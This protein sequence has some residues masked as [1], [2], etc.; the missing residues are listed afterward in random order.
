[1]TEFIDTIIVGG[2]QGGLSVSYHLCQQGREH[3]IFEKAHRAAQVWRNRWD[4]FT[5]ITPNWMVRMP[6]APYQ[7]DNPDGFM[8]KDEIVTYF[9]SYINRFKLPI[10]YGVRVTSIKPYNNGYRVFTNNGNY[11][12]KNVVVAVGLYQKAKMP[13]CYKKLS[14][15]IQQIHSSEYK[16]PEMLPPGAVLVVGSGQSGSQIAEELYQSG[17]KVFL[18]V[19]AAGRVPRRYRGL[20]VAL[21]MEKMGYY[22]R[23][24]SELSSP[25]DK[26]A[27]SAHGTGKNGG[28]TIN[29]HQFA[30]EG[31]ILLGQVKDIDNETL[32]IKMNLKENL[33]KA[34]QFEQDFI[35]EVDQYI[36]SHKLD[37]PDEQLPKFTEGYQAKEINKLDLKQAGIRTVI[38]A[39]GYKFDFSWIQLPIFDDDGYPIQAR[40]V[41]DYPGLYFIGLPFLHNGISGVIAGV[42]D[43]AAHI[44]SVI[45][46][47]N[48]RKL[49]FF[50]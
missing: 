32:I 15:E 36:E 10:K 8:T 1:M 30:K 43:D 38:W 50:I 26:F 31:V 12:A 16:N 45:E 39:T 41:T 49:Q 44:A 23:L 19:G 25:K 34:D 21:W 46:K 2:G 3:L 9:E 29:L 11:A 28:H 47:T 13:L 33:A 24:V 14:A 40:G 42:G 22:K 48:Q 37:F 7:G 4:S 17:R 5:L 6:G 35:D 18:S 27:G 20:D